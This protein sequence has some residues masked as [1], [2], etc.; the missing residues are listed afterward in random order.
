MKTLRRHTDWVNDVKL[1]EDGLVAVST[2][3]DKT[4]RIWNVATGECVRVLKAH[5][6]EI[7]CLAFKD[8]VIVTGSEDTTLRV[9]KFLFH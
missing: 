6:D 8:N 4:V 2:G 5:A 3:K 1:D 9:W 7:H